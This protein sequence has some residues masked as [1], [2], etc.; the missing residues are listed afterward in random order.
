MA[1]I[2]QNI[3]GMTLTGSILALLAFVVLPVTKKFLP[4]KWHCYLFS[5]ILLFFLLPVGTTATTLFNKI[6]NSTLFVR[7][8]NFAALWDEIPAPL[9]MAMNTQTQIGLD[10]V[11]ILETILPFLPIVWI[12]GAIVFL[13]IKFS[14]LIRFEKILAKS[15]E[16]ITDSTILDVSEHIKKDLKISKSVSLLRNS[17]IST[18]LLMGLIRTRLLMPQIDFNDEELELVLRHELTHYRNRDLWIKFATM[19]A[20]AIHWFNPCI[21]L[22]SNSLDHFLEM[23][24][25]ADVVK[26]MDRAQRRVYGTTILNILDRAAFKQPRVYAA[27]SSNKKAMKGR[28]STMLNEKKQTKKAVVIS[29]LILVIICAAGIGVSAAVN[30]ETDTLPLLTYTEMKREALTYTPIDPAANDALTLSDYTEIEHGISIYTSAEKTRFYVKMDVPLPDVDENLL[31]RARID[32]ELVAE[33]TINPA[34][35]DSK[36]WSF[37]FS[38]TGEAGE[39]TVKIY[40]NKVLYQ[41]IPMKVPGYGKIYTEDETGIPYPLDFQEGTQQVLPSFVWP[42]ENIGWLGSGFQEYEGH[43]GMDIIVPIDTTIYASEDGIVVAARNTNIGYGKYI[44]I[45]HGSGFQTLYAHCNELNVSV[46]SEVKAGQVIAAS[47]R[48][49]STTGYQLHFEIRK[50]GE[51]LNPKDYINVDNSPMELPQ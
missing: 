10:K 17:C 47:G 48:S 14:Q 1:N 34:T 39:I 18:P 28:L 9:D 49:G 6:I 33:A 22:L 8:S 50:N 45:D 43:T 51:S 30:K 41:N 7:E 16:Q 15:N 40:V 32:D 13:I 42:T 38:Y 31:M 23:S 24:C 19:L 46:G 37:D 12:I 36:Y 2:F 26:K 4:P 11:T 21:Y 3:F 44:V 20:C 27:F 25:D 35:N 29:A 5:T